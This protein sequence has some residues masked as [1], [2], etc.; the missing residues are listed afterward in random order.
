M[1]YRVNGEGLIIVML[2]SPMQR[3]SGSLW[4]S[5]CTIMSIVSSA[6]VLF[7]WF[8]LFGR[9]AGIEVSALCCLFANETIFYFKLF[10]TLN[11]DGGR[12]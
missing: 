1:R 8:I 6:F 5:L 2:V 10:L 3:D 4:T 9:G 7:G 12:G 11:R